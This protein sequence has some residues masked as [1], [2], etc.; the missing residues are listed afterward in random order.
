MPSG[1]L[2]SC[3]FGLQTAVFKIM[4]PGPARIGLVGIGFAF[5]GCLFPA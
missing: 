3:G 2:G 5:L 1:G 4:L